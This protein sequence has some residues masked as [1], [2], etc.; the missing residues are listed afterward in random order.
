[1]EITQIRRDVQ[2]EAV[3]GHPTADVDADGGDLTIAYPY[4]GEFGNARRFDSVVGE[5]LDNRLL[6]AADV[7]ADIALPIAQIEDGVAHQLTGAVIGHVAAAVRWIE[8]YA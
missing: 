7:G 8:R 3:R 4:S 1:M 5:S 2:R 6:D